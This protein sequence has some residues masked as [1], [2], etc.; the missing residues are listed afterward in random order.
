MSRSPDHIVE[1]HRIVR[2]RR[3]AGQPVWA[4]RLNIADIWRNEALTFEQQRDA[5]VSRLRASAWH[6]DSETVQD[7]TDTLADT[8]NG[9]EFDGPLG[10]AVRRG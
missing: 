2:A 5:I 8:K 1:T 9:D 7:L 10:R 3:A 4:H 6:Q